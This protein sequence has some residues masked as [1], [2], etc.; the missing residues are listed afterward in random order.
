MLQHSCAL[1][2]RA[3]ADLVRLRAS[4]SRSARLHA[5]QTCAPGEE[6]R[7]ASWLVPLFD[8]FEDMKSVEWLIWA[9]NQDD[10]VRVDPELKA[11]VDALKWRPDLVPGTDKVKTCRYVE[12]AFLWRV[13][14]TH[15]TADN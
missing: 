5:K 13:K 14:T 6:Q 15:N 7:R 11:K 2:T 8:Q 3:G 10:P 4:E 12:A 1:Q 9:M